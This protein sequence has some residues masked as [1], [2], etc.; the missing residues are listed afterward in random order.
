MINKIIK[1]KLLFSR[2]SNWNYG[3]IEP[4]LR[5]EGKIT[6]QS[7]L[8]FGESIKMVTFLII[9]R[10]EITAKLETG[11]I[12]GSFTLLQHNMGGFCALTPLKQKIFFVATDTPGS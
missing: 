7:N 5:K 8:L 10:W 1:K 3:S 6:Q 11:C 2:P 12:H 9:A 4:E